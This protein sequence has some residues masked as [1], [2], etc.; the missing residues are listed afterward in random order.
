MTFPSS[1]LCAVHHPGGLEIDVSLVY[2][3]YC[4]FEAMARYLH[5]YNR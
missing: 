1:E 3:D 2:G 4:L 5:G